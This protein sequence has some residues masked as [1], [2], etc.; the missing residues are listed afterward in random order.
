MSFFDIPS[1]KIPHRL[2]MGPGPSMVAKSILEKMSCAPV[3]HLDPYFLLLMDEIKRMLREIFQTSNEF[4]F[5]ISGTGSA[6]M[7]FC[8]VNLVEPQDKVLIGINGL[9][10]R[11]I[12]DLALKLGADVHTLE[13][14][15]GESIEAEEL[16]KALEKTQP[17][18]VALVHAET[19]TGIGN[20]VEELAPLISQSGALFILDTV[21]SLGGSPVFID[22][23]KVD[24]TFSATQKCIGAP[25]GLAPVSFSPKAM[26]V[27]LKRKTKIP[28]WYFDCSLLHGY[29]GTERIYHHTAPINNNFGL[30][31]ALRLILEEGLQKRWERHQN[32]HL[33]LKKGLSKLGLTFFTPENRRLWQLNAVKVP[34]GKDEALLRKKLLDQYGIEI[35]PGL[36]P[37]KGK[38]WRIGLMAEG[39]QQKYIDQLLDALENILKS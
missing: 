16:Q 18:L 24:A 28:S 37:L 9:F 29:W 15:W 35:G 7:E 17:K 22:R 30:H 3:G 26:E 10:G 6:G 23:W 27:V 2:L 25:P 21:T 14:P 39:A 5:P 12:A 8:L 4:T 1:L 33:Q 36:G 20:P 34:E 32:A 31:E 11:R 19:S 13:V 38:I